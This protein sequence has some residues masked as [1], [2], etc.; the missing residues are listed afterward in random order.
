MKTTDGSAPR[1]K[2]GLSRAVVMS[3]MGALIATPRGRDVTIWKSSMFH[4]DKR[5]DQILEGH[6][7]YVQ[8]IVF[9]S[10][11]VHIASI[12]LDGTVRIWKTWTWEIACV[13]RIPLVGEV[14]TMAMGATTLQIAI[15]NPDGSV[16]HQVISTREMGLEP[17][18]D[19]AIS[20]LDPSVS[21]LA[22]PELDLGAIPTIPDLTLTI[23]EKTESI[24]G[25]DETETACPLPTTERTDV[26]AFMTLHP[27]AGDGDS[28]ITPAFSGREPIS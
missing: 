26:T 12:A 16:F 6:T 7:H 20:Q 14:Q 11:G 21:S 28:P 8:S 17:E 2:T 5:P 23:A 27:D 22:I 4:S 1:V 10:D 18:T 3:P 13:V 19:L 24:T 15:S 9:S 25:H